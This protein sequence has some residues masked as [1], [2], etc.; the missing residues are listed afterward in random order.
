ME[1]KLSAQK[2]ITGGG[3]KHIYQHPENLDLL[4]KIWRQKHFYSVKTRHPVFFKFMRLP[5]YS[6]LLNEIAEHLALREEEKDARFIQTITGF[7]DTDIGMGL[8]VEP[9][10]EKTVT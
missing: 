3:E 7:V 1:Y 5:R 6:A 2:P 4:I 9:V 8:V 10:R